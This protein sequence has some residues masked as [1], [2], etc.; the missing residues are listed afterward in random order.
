[1]ITVEAAKS[2]LKKHVRSLDVVQQPIEVAVGMV[3]SKDIRAAADMPRFDQSA[4][5]GYAIVLDKS[6]KLVAN[7][8]KV[9]H[10]IKAGDAPLLR[11][12]RNAAY[13]IFTGAP[14]PK[15]TFCIVMQE[16]VA[17]DG[18]DIILSSDTIKH[19]RHIRLR[20]GNF[21]KGTVVLKKGVALTPAAIGLLA[22]LGAVT[23]PVYRRPVIG[24][25]VTGNELVQ[26]GNLLRTGQIYESNSMSLRAALQSSGFSLSTIVRARDTANAVDRALGKLL[27]ACDVV[28]VTGGISVGKYDFVHA[29]LQK[30]RVREL[31]YKVAQKPGKPLFA[32]TR[33]KKLIF[34]L[35]GNPAA[36]LVCYHEYVLPSLRQMVGKTPFIIK[37]L[38]MEHDFRWSGDRAQ[39]F[40]A[41][42][43]ENSVN[44][45]AAQ[46]S[47]N[48]LS[49]AEA[50]ALV[51]LSKGN[52]DL[53]KGDTVEV[54][55]LSSGSF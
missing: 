1:M 51:Y 17:L 47:D 54:H 44:I 20:G 8:F 11:T 12:Q 5:D 10:E 24:L 23:V 27:A 16:Q 52:H 33:R 49:F 31:F 2:I 26:A 29:S 19:L 43:G 36:V 41:N 9:L 6:S 53:L 13:R 34:A 14:V 39:F 28:L 40:R 38:P 21:R 45:L 25:L 18:G 32:G 15:G 46:D 7:R 30:Q 35:P 3:L 42:M 4:V 50:N 22:A 55:P 37:H 48:L